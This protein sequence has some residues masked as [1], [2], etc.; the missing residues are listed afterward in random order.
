VFQLGFDVLIASSKIALEPSYEI[1]PELRARIDQ[2]RRDP[3]VLGYFKQVA[4][5]ELWRRYFH[6]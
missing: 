6:A 3:N 4:S 5:K 1:I 2:A